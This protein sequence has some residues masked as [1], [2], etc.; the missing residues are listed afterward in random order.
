WLAFDST[1]Q[2]AGGMIFKFLSPPS[3]SQI[4]TTE[5]K[6]IVGRTID[7]TRDTINAALQLKQNGNL[8]PSQQL[9]TSQN[10]EWVWEIG[11][12]EGL[13]TVTVS[14]HD[15]ISNKDTD[16]T[17][18]I[19]YDPGDTSDTDPPVIAD[20]QA[21][22]KYAD[23]SR[24]PEDTVR[25][26]VIAFDD[27]TGI[28]ILTI[29]EDTITQS[30]KTAYY[31]FETDLHLKHHG[32]NSIPVTATDSAGNIKDLNVVIFKNN[33]PHIVQALDPPDPFFAGSTYTDT[34]LVADK[35]NDP[36]T[37]SIDS[38]PAGFLL[39]EN[40]AVSWA[41]AASQ[42]GQH[43]I[44]I[45]VSDEL[46]YV[47]WQCTLE[48]LP[49]INTPC[50]LAVSP[51]KGTLLDNIISVYDTIESETIVFDIIDQDNMRIEDYTVLVKY[52]NATTVK[53]VDSTRFT[54]TLSPAEAESSYDSL[55]VVC[56]D[57]SAQP[58]T[59]ALKIVYL[60]TNDPCTLSVVS[61]QGLLSNDTL[62]INAGSGVDSL[63]YT[64]NDSDSLISE[65]YVL[66]LIRDGDTSS[67]S[68]S[69][70]RTFSVI[71]DPLAHQKSGEKITAICGDNS[72][73]YD[74]LTIFVAYIRDEF[75]QKITFNTTPAGAGISSTL[76]EFPILL[77]LD[78]SNFSF[79]AAGD[80]GEDIWFT[81]ESGDTMLHNIEFYDPSAQIAALWVLNDSIRANDNTQFIT[82]HYGQQAPRDFDNVE[83]FRSSN[84]FVGVWH[85]G[86]IE[87]NYNIERFITPDKSSNSQ[88]GICNGLLNQGNV[89]DGYCGKAI[90]FY[91]DTPTGGD[92]IDL[93]D[94]IQYRME[95]YTISFWMKADND[96][97][98]GT[99]DN[100]EKLF[101]KGNQ[102]YEFVW[103]HND[104]AKMTSHQ[105]RLGT[106][107]WGTAR[108]TDSL[109]K[110]TWY[111]VH[112]TL[113]SNEQIR[114][115]LN[116][117]SY[118]QA[119][120]ND[121]SADTGTLSLAGDAN[122]NYYYFHGIIDEFRFCSTCR[123][124]EWIKLEYE[125]QRI[126][127]NFITFE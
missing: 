18:I 5:R 19:Y 57:L 21:D 91:G 48:V 11:L 113:F 119:F 67:P 59:L 116:G 10:E 126:D 34:L 105:I 99:W 85:M 74:T 121:Y 39:N 97:A 6:T 38:A 36:I 120:A 24:T 123:S 65:N 115:Y 33:P 89:V 60:Q 80:S 17:I 32:S 111:L 23:N 63:A 27:G 35:D 68:I 44:R 90:R 125:N 16:S 56:T 88:H 7:I 64:I 37:T 1:M 87:Y 55:L 46:Q 47:T 118:G 75:L 40:N 107:N 100:L 61:K 114:V 14:A 62:T 51:Q 96:L 124:E 4:V 8:H 94:R 92:W 78:S 30:D 109:E 52:R 83:I 53:S 49:K 70:D 110:N 104:S 3:D 22:G 108:I 13:N 20:V 127:G 41:P 84:G 72:G 2:P 76:F 122:D 86:T 45:E 54:I 95:D 29:H 73:Q 77:R 58:D 101:C 28:E 12:A 43:L 50:S 81:S 66:S 106:H 79:A 25:I 26:K 117:Q 102:Q 9:L 103:G 71:I 69:I 42:A 31:L 82:M 15:N 112:C 98:Y 93:G